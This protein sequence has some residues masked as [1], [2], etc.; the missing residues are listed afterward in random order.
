MAQFVPQPNRDA[1]S[2]IR[3]YIY[4]VDL[5]I[6]RWL[7]LPT[8]HVLE[9]E[10][11]EDID[12][13]S[14]AFLAAGEEQRRLLEQVKHREEALT[15]RTPAALEALAN[16][17]TH[18]QRNPDVA[19]FFRYTTNARITRER[20]SGL[21]DHTPA[22]E[23]W[24]QLRT[25]IYPRDGVSVALAGIRALLQNARRP[26]DLAEDNWQ[27]FLT[28]FDAATDDELLAF[29]T[30]FE[31]S[32]GTVDAASMHRHIPGILL[33]KHY[34]ADIDESQELYQRLFFFVFKLLSQPGT[35]RLTQQHLQEQIAR[36][37]LSDADR[38]L[39]RSVVGVL[40]TLD[41]RVQALEQNSE[42]QSTLLTRLTYEMGQLVRYRELDVAVAYT[43][44]TPVVELPPLEGTVS[45]RRAAVQLLRNHLDN[46]TW[47]ALYG[48]SGTGKTVLANL[49]ARSVGT[50]RLWL[51]LRD[52]SIPQ[53][54]QRFDAACR[55]FTSSAFQPRLEWYKLVCERL[56][57]EAIVVLDDIPRLTANDE[58]SDRLVLFIA[59]CRDRNIRLLTTSPHPLPPTLIA[60]LNQQTVHVMATPA[61][62]EDDVAETLQAYGAPE[63]VL[64]TATIR[65]IH[66]LSHQH[67]LLVV[68]IVRELQE[69]NW[70]FDDVAFEAL[71]RQNY[72][73]DINN[74]TMHALLQHVTD[75]QSRELLYRTNLPFGSF[76]LDEV[77]DLAAV[78]PAIDRPYERMQLLL[79]LWIQRD[80]ANRMVV[81]PLIKALGS[82]DLRPVTLQNCYGV[83]GNRIV[84]KGALSL[85]DAAT[86]IAYFMSAQQEERAGKLFA[87]ALSFIR[88]SEEQ[89]DDAGLLIYWGTLPLPETMSLGTRIYVRAQQ[90]AIRRSRGMDAE[91]L[92]ND[93]NTLIDGAGGHEAW[94]II[95]LLTS[96][97]T[98][99]PNILLSHLA[100]VLNLLPDARLP[101]G[102]LIDP[103]I[104]VRLG[105]LIWFCADTLTTVDQLQQWIDV[106]SLLSAEQQHYAFNDNFA[107]RSCIRVADRLWLL[108][109]EKPVEN[110]EWDV[111]NAALINLAERAWNLQLLLLWACAVRA[112]IMVLVDYYHD[113][114][115]A[116]AV[117]EAAVTHSIDDV[118]AQFLLY[119]CL[120]RQYVYANRTEEAEYWL[121]QAVSQQ[122][123]SYTN[124]RVRAWL[125]LSSII[126]IR[127]PQSA[128]TY[129]QQ[130]VQLAEAADEIP[131]LTIVKA[132]CELA[133]AY[134]LISDLQATFDSWDSAGEHLLANRSDTD[135]W[136]EVFVIYG[137]VSGYLTMLATRG[138]PP[139]ELYDG[140]PY[141]APTRG[142]FLTY[143][144]QRVRFYNR[145][146]DSLLMAQ[147]TM[148]AEAVRRDD[149]MATW[150]AYGLDL[151]R[152]DQQWFVFTELSRD[153]IPHL[154]L[155]DRYAE[156]LDAAL[157]FGPL[158]EAL[159][160]L[161]RRN[162]DPL[163]DTLNVEELLGP[164]PNR[165]WLMADYRSAFFGLIPIVFRLSTIAGDQRE[166]A[167]TQALE[168]A[169]LCRQ[170]S[171]NRVYQQLWETA[172]ALFE[173]IGAERPGFNALMERSNELQG[174]FDNVLQTIGYLGAL[175]QPE[176][177]LEGAL[178]IHLNVVPLVYR[179]FTPPSA[180]YRQ[181]ILPYLTQYWLRAIEQERFRFRTPVIVERDLQ[182][183]RDLPERERAQAI[184]RTVV[185]GLGMVVSPDVQQWLRPVIE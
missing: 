107:D 117:G 36:P 49:C 72:A 100:T 159:Q 24:E 146:R 12:L 179:L 82:R 34:A 92:I 85:T 184:L 111:I 125:Y 16:A 9:L 167:C 115:T 98:L 79:D 122:T 173:T 29:I 102:E 64:T 134:W 74:E 73:A 163:Q 37:L 58:L 4:Q 133:I 68:G 160:E 182:R 91:Y 162:G 169:S 28:F 137:H 164:K 140:Q 2:T 76:S 5:T 152:T 7:N 118:R 19:L 3:G 22:I 103:D 161:Y 129:A 121:E 53:A 35:K 32:T 170:I 171:V 20:A 178:A 112:R 93:V 94:A 166:Q 128:I 67:P 62:T 25:G 69:R 106:V 145:S 97:P 33:Q 55:D 138:E 14:Q 181:I 11:G 51:R 158:Y 127:D 96:N 71:L 21:P 176:A 119:E 113:L 54:C 149:R 156:V 174:E 180:M 66:S 80:S 108:E 45:Q 141:T 26:Q 123:D 136:K 59:A 101:N 183:Y 43:N 15:L 139:T 1:W 135:A 172:A 57:P 155:S 114:D 23:L 39:L 126:G 132:H 70:R 31:W 154:L 10:C 150:A 99:N 42:N 8:D 165:Q 147:L 38:V 46:I 88:T 168:V 86:A 41:Q 63:Q 110:R 78:E 87:H 17:I 109:A 95:G 30:T 75:T 65:T 104:L 47:L 81:S 40:D 83:L 148:F 177:T 89:I 18:R 105:S 142:I 116:V 13:V 77:Y 157:D 185:Y 6:E 61:F 27:T 120:G 144:S 56:G 151:A 90:V 143:N 52:L 44:D 124:E 130:A 48:S 153:M 50:C 131:P 175:W 60:R 84:G